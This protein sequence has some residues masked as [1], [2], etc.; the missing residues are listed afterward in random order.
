M[1][2]VLGSDESRALR[3]VDLLLSQCEKVQ[4]VALQWWA[5]AREPQ[6]V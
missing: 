4:G 2:K 6:G 5:C 1:R 3:P